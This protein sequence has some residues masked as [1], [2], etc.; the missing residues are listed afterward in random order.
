MTYCS[1]VAVPTLVGLTEKNFGYYA[2]L[3]ILSLRP[4]N[5]KFSF[6]PLT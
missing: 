6:N 3:K 4:P 1:V 2:I 5:C